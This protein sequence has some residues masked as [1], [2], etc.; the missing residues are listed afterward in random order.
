M[1]AGA[2]Y[3]IDSIPG[4]WLQKLDPSVKTEIEKQVPRLLAIAATRKQG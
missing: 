2:T 4:G 1:L 3:G